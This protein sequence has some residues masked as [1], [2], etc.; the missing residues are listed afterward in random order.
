[1]NNQLQHKFNAWAV[2]SVL[3]SVKIW[4]STVSVSYRLKQFTKIWADK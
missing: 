2:T 3:S 1:M 4:C